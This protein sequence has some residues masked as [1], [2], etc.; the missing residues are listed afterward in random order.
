MQHYD[1]II[2]GSGPA[3]SAAAA[4]LARSGRSVLVLEKAKH[5]R[6][7][8]C[9]GGLSARLLRYLDEDVKEVIERNILHLSFRFKKKEAV[10]SSATPVAYLVA[11]SRFDAYLVD[12]AR[13][14][15][16]EI[17]ES[18]PMED[19]R[20]TP[21]GVEVQSRAGRETASFLVAADGAGS[22]VAQKVYPAWIQRRAFSLEAE[23]PLR[24][25]EETVWIDLTVPRG[26]G[27]VFP[28]ESGAAVGVADFRGK[29]QR[30]HRLYLDF[31]ERQALL[32]E[33]Q[34]TFP[35]GCT[36]PIHQQPVPSLVRGRVLL[37]GDAA[38]LVDPLFG[39]GI[40]YAIRSGQMAAK[41]ISA[42]F[43]GSKKTESYDEE[44]REAFYP[45][46]RVA[47][48]LAKWVY[49]FPALFLEM[50]RRHPAAMELYLDVLRGKRTYCDFWRE[51]KWAFL[52][53][54][55]PF[56]RTAV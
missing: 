7:K 5:P 30:P 38:G 8:S 37:V 12:K 53:K 47:G 13:E 22:R 52:Q 41:A 2:V 4:A 48:F 42:S 28:K 49:T 25:K 20:E 55:I 24:T 23:I 43:T 16:A 3:G 50:T 21:E 32:S 35:K 10:F 51:V 33:A 17:R 6:H 14:A 45:D 26:Y 40:F 27:W 11:R 36:I 44:F 34:Q 19:W 29:V 46:F 54:W 15:G 1:I 18:C 39:E 56:R 31:I 9:G